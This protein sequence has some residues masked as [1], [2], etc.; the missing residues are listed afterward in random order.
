VFWI[1]KK[2]QGKNPESSRDKKQNTPESRVATNLV[3]N[4]RVHFAF[5]SILTE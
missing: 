1:L 5:S 3:K 4:A 2:P